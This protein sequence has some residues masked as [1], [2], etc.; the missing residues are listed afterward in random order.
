L[1][2]FLRFNVSYLGALGYGLAA[3]PVLVNGFGWNPLIAAAAVMGSGVFL[4]YV[5]HMRYSF[6]AF[7]KDETE[8]P[9]SRG[10]G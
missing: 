8:V 7:G 2:E 1:P 10:N 4:S 5:L 9:P 3:L 6:R